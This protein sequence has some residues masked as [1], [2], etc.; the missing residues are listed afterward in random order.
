[1]V[2]RAWS[3]YRLPLC[4]ATCKW[5]QLRKTLPPL[6]QFHL[7]TNLN[8]RVAQNSQSLANAFFAVAQHNAMGYSPFSIESLDTDRTLHVAGAYDV[9]R[10]L[11]PLILEH[12]GKGDMAG[13]LLDDESQKT[14]LQ[15]GDFVFNVAHEYSWRYAIRSQGEPPRFGGLII[16]LSRDEFIIAGAGLIVTFA[17]RSGDAI[18]GIASLDEGA[19]IDGKW[20]PG[21]RMNGDQSHQGRHL[22][23]PGNAFGI[24]KVRLYLYK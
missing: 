4:R 20:A 7:P 12:Q 2:L 13:V 8:G 18:A 15:L 3:L 5:R 14:Q 19:F 17:P 23:L 9:L 16:M 24:Q 1:M 10:Q 11:A 22:H 21:R 6:V